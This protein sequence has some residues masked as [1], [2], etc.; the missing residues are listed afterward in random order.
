LPCPGTARRIRVVSSLRTERG[1]TAVEYAG[2]LV[3]VGLL[4][5]ALFAVVP[6]IG[7]TI[8]HTVE[9]L[10]PGEGCAAAGTA[11]SGDDAADASGPGSSQ[12]SQPAA[13]PTPVSVPT[14]A[15]APAA[16]PGWTGQAARLPRGGTR[17]YVPPKKSHGKPQRTKGSSGI[18][19]E[20][21]HGNVWV[22]D[23][24]GQHW[25]VQH[26]KTGKHT[27]VNP[28]GSINHG[29]DNFPNRAPGDDS[30]GSSDDN[31]AKSVGILGGL[32][33]GGGILWW[34]GK[35]A[36]PLCGPALPACAIVF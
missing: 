30:S 34:A 5:A 9:C 27:N 19:F 21:E 35:A 16:A 20:D 13:A 33:A 12:G 7:G 1:Q 31:T 17:P 4:L 14:P 26:P 24:R 6:R 2:V 23:P 11:P 3:L 18:G 10:V 22:W 25:D 32:L 29:P 15:P 36:S 8:A 28:D